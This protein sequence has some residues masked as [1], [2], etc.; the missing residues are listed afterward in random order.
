MLGLS[1]VGNHAAFFVLIFFFVDSSAPRGI[2]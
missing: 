2:V 1:C